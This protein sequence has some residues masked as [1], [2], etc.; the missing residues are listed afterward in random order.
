MTLG[1]KMNIKVL[2][3][4]LLHLLHYFLPRP[5]IVILKRRHTYLCYCSQLSHSQWQSEQPEEPQQKVQFA[6]L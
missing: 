6:T 3:F 2:P 4:Q 1:I 5:G